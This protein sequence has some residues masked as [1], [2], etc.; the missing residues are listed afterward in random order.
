MYAQCE[1]WIDPPNGVRA[2]FKGKGAAFP[3]GGAYTCDLYL[4]S[5]VSYQDLLTKSA[6][7]SIVTVLFYVNVSFFS[8]E[9]EYLGMMHGGGVG[10]G[11]G[12]FVGQFE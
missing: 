5:G 8:A 11:G 12:G 9:H 10:V 2:I 4:E 6:S 3:G 1:I 7:C